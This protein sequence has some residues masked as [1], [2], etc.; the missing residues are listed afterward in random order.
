G[1]GQTN[2]ASVDG[3][4][5]TSVFPKPL[6]P[7]TVTIGGSQALVGYAGAAPYEVAGVLQVNVQIPPDTPSGPATVI[8]SVGNHQSAAVTIAVQ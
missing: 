8:L 3:K 7:V 6:L 4:L 1:E 5:A 2:P